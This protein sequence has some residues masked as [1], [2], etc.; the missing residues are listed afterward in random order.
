MENQNIL[1]KKLGLG[2]FPT[3][4]N[5]YLKQNQ[6]LKQFYQSNQNYNNNI[7]NNIYNQRNMTL[8]FPNTGMQ[9]NLYNK[10]IISNQSNDY[11]NNFLK[12]KEENSFHKESNNIEIF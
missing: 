7:D 10:N 8:N 1:Q 5:L 3:P 12:Q 9:N 11:N 4:P 6:Q 2:L